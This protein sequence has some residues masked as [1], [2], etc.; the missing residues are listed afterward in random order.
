MT[1]ARF[2]LEPGPSSGSCAILRELQPLFCLGDGRPLRLT[3]GDDHLA[4]RR[5]LR[6]SQGRKDWSRLG[7]V[8]RAYPLEHRRT[9]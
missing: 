7:R 9:V 4:G 2:H 6:V 1:R 3:G 5:I 8:E